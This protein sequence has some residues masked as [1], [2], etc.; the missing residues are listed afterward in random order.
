MGNKLENEATDRGIKGLVCN[1][2]SCSRTN[3]WKPVAYTTNPRHPSRRKSLL[4][5]FL[6]VQTPSVGA[7]VCVGWARRL[8]GLS[9]FQH[10]EGGSD[11]R[12][13]FNSSQ[14]LPIS[15]LCSAPCHSTHAACRCFR[16]SLLRDRERRAHGRHRSCS[17]GGQGRRHRSAKGLYD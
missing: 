4:N 8:V 15:A 14:L 7:R 10:A 2:A 1:V 16:A 13:P 12:T 5:R 17:A 3:S 9:L 11:A 6:R